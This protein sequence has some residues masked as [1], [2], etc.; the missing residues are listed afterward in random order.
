V[1]WCFPLQVLSYHQELST[2]S[3]AVSVALSA[4]REDLSVESLHGI[5]PLKV[6]L[7]SGYF[8]PLCPSP[9]LARRFNLISFHVQ[10]GNHES[11]R[12]TGTEPE[13]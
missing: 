6:R 2:L 10:Q 12:E 5:L 1:T 4:V 3:A 13:K 11:E 7:A 8:F 9:S